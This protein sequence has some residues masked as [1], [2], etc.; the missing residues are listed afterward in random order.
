MP[1]ETLLQKR[2]ETA[3]SAIV[4][5][6][7]SHPFNNSIT[8]FNLTRNKRYLLKESSA[9]TPHEDPFAGKT[10]T[11]ILVSDSQKRNQTL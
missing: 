9:L 1:L 3:I 2:W 6:L 10:G 8:L 5:S 11:H 7:I 4:W